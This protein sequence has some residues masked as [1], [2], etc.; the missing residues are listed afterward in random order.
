MNGR[1]VI[2]GYLLLWDSC[3]KSAILDAPHFHVLPRLASL[4]LDRL[5]ACH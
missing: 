1:P 3:D 4:V 2:F 5:G